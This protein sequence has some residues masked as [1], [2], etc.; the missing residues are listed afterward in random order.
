M[1]FGYTILYVQDVRLTLD[2]YEKAFGF[3]TRFMLPTNDYGELDLQGG[4]TLAFA[5]ENFVQKSIG[6]NAFRPN[7]ET[8]TTAAGA[9]ISFL[10]EKGESIEGSF[11][12]AV[13]AGATIVVNPVKKPWGQTVAYLRDCNGFLV[14]ICTP[15]SEDGEVE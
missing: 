5:A 11:E 10:I 14:E 3:S 6:A 9:E 12:K 15:V 8:D 4:T 7:R 1:K 13:D 2:F